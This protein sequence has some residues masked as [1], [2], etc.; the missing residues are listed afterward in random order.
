M[1]IRFSSVMLRQIGP[2]SKCVVVAAVERPVYELYLRN[3][4]VNKKLQFFFDRIEIAE[5]QTL[6][7]GGKAVTSGERAP[8]AGFIV[9]DLISEIFH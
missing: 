5:P 7:Y 3:F 4:P 6:V 1:K 8:P 9:E 2:D